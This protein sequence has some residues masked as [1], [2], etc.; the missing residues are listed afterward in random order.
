MKWKSGEISLLGYELCRFQRPCLTAADMSWI[1]NKASVYRGLEKAV[2][3]YSK[4]SAACSIFVLFLQCGKF[5]F[6]F[7]FTRGGVGG[8]AKNRVEWIVTGPIFTQQPDLRDFFKFCVHGR[9]RV[10]VLI[11]GHHEVMDCISF[12]PFL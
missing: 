8:M 6:F 7:F 10:C 9:I 4:R 12:D 5:F 1:P 11:N 2:L 3:T